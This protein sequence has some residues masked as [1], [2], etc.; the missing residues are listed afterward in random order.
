MRVSVA[1]SSAVSVMRLYVSGIVS[2][3]SAAAV[4][5]VVIVCGVA[6]AN[7]VLSAPCLVLVF[8]DEQELVYGDAVEY[9]ICAYGS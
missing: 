7:V 3:Q 4:S 8:S 6:V 1:L 5:L 2:W 9:V